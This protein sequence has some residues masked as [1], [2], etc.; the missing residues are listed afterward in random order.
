MEL[1]GRKGG[2]G[3]TDKGVSNMV[4]REL[5]L[6]ALLVKL[7]WDGHDTSVEQQDV[8]LAFVL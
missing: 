8:K 5:D 3:G 6:D 2:K 7:K 1:T 4:R